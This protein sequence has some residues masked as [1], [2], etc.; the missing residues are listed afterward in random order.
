MRCEQPA[1]G[2]FRLGKKFLALDGREAE[3][4]FQGERPVAF[5]RVLHARQHL[6]QRPQVDQGEDPAEGVRAGR[7]RAQTAAQAFRQLSIGL[8]GVE[9]FAPRGQEREHHP[10]DVLRRDRRPPSRVAQRRH[11][12]GQIQDLVGIAT[13]P[14]HHGA[15]FRERGL[16]ALPFSRNNCSK[17]DCEISSKRRSISCADSTQA[18]ARCSHSGGK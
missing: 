7:T 3:V 9:T 17:Q 4:P 13:K 11:P 16:R 1:Q 18:R 2:R 6:A 5:Q 14:G 12:L 15:C 10:P 8:P